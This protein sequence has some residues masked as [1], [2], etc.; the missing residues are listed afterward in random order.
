MVGDRSGI[1]RGAG[2][3]VGRICCATSKPWANVGG[4]PEISVKP[5][6]RRP[7]RCCTAGSE[8]VT[9]RSRIPALPATGGP[10]GARWSGC[11]RPAQDRRGL[12]GNF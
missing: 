2:S 5:C 9:A 11:W 6:K 12:S 1:P 10:F 4:G 8:S 7:V 3:A